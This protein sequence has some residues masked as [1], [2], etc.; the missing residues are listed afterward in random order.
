MMSDKKI[1]TNI[2]AIKHYAYVLPAPPPVFNSWTTLNQ[3]PSFIRRSTARSLSTQVGKCE[4]S[5]V[6]SMS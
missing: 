1:N 5:L 2:A 4:F 3:S 6:S